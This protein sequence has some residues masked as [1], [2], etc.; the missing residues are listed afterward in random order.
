LW[1][2]VIDHFLRRGALWLVKDVGTIIVIFFCLD[3]G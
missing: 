1:A 3:N 2:R